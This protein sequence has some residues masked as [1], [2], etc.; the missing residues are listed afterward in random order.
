MYNIYVEKESFHRHFT[1]LT[2]QMQYIF[3][4]NQVCEKKK[5]GKSLQENVQG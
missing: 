2:H 1:D 5:I 3:S 4:W